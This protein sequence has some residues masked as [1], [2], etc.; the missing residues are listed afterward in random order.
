MK[1]FTQLFG[2]IV[3]EQLYDPGSFWLERNLKIFGIIIVF[4]K[5][6]C[7]RTWVS[8]ELNAPLSSLLCSASM[9]FLSIW[10]YQWSFGCLHQVSGWFRLIQA[11]LYRSI[12]LSIIRLTQGDPLQICVAET[13]KGLSLNAWKL[14]EQVFPTLTRAMVLGKPFSTCFWPGYWLPLCFYIPQIMPK[15]QPV[16]LLWDDELTGNTHHDLT[17]LVT[18]RTE[19]M[20]KMDLVVSGALWDF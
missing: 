5:Q 1:Q 6:V 9:R 4:F 11:F 20:E 18:D 14:A 7:I 13:C 19:R 10:S 15:Y 8:Y 17:L 12:L 2:Q 3:T 16:H